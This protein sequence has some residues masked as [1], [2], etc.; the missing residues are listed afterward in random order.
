MALVST[1]WRNSL[2]FGAAAAVVWIGQRRY[3]GPVPNLIDWNRVADAATRFGQIEEPTAEWAANR[4][5]L[6]REYAGMV[7][8]S[9]RAIGT[10]LGETL[11]TEATVHVFDRRD[12]VAAN[13]ESFKLLFEPFER[14]YQTT[15][16]DHTL[17]GLAV[18]SAGRLFL[19][20]ELGILVAFLARRVLGQY[21]LALLG[22]EPLTNGRL[23]FVEPNIERLRDALDLDGREFRL[24]IAL[25]E[26][27]HAYE[28]E[29]HPWLREH[30]NRLILRYFDAVTSDLATIKR[31]GGLIGIAQR[32]VGNVWRSE[33]AFEWVMNV[34]QRAVF[35]QLQALMCLLEG[36]SNHV[37]D[38]VGRGLLPT[39]PR[40]KVLFDQRLQRRSAGEK[41]FARLTGLDLKYEQ[42]VLGERFVDEVVRARG[43]GFASRVWTSDW[44]LP[45]LDEIRQ[46]ARWIERVGG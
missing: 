41:L 29:Q 17:G 24:W 9:R 46:P 45:T 25:H 39:Y 16:F 33:H 14:V 8:E 1:L 38:E 42:Y 32:A 44:H 22:R 23:F 2:L 5:P 27:T 26:A 20:T 11:P 30:M 28:F 35:R 4:E 40:M 31:A 43:L 10:Y 36:Y 34:E 3:R 21:D 13:L 7:R 15:L 18:G 37:M 6:G 19:S 12:W